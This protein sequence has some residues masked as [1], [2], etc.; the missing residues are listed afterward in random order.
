MHCITA[1]FAF[2][3][4]RLFEGF[5][6]MQVSVI[7]PVQEEHCSDILHA[8]TLS[9]IVQPALRIQFCSRTRNKLGDLEEGP[10]LSRIQE[11]C[12]STSTLFALFL[13]TGTKARGNKDNKMAAVQF[14]HAFI[15]D[16]FKRMTST[17]VELPKVK[18]R[19]QII[20]LNAAFFRVDKSKLGADWEEFID[21]WRHTHK[22]K[23][24]PNLA[25]PENARVHDLYA[26]LMLSSD[27]SWKHIDKASCKTFRKE[28][29]TFTAVL[30]HTLDKHVR[31]ILQQNG[32][33][34]I[35][36]LLVSQGLEERWVRRKDRMH[37]SY[38]CVHYYRTGSHL[39]CTLVQ[40]DQYLW[41]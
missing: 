2:I 24:I 33:D 12:V 4:M 18:F 17:L 3:A 5:S 23:L 20:D 9:E 1:V 7:A 29:L 21:E 32:E 40:A 10:I 22:C 35:N 8:Q 26:V 41:P 28:L 34:K 25:L 6:L 38:S 37:C 31:D 16:I 13:H 14:V 30:S 36:G 15:G 19:K 11:H 39:V 27:P